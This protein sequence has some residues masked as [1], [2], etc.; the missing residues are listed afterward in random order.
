MNYFMET[1]VLSSL[2]VG[3][4]VIS[5]FKLYEPHSPGSFQILNPMTTQSSANSQLSS[6]FDC[7]Y[8]RRAPKGTPQAEFPLTCSH[9]H[10]TQKDQTENRSSIST[11]TPDESAHT[12]KQALR[13]DHL[14]Q[15]PLIVKLSNTKR[16]GRRKIEFAN[17]PILLLCRANKKLVICENIIKEAVGFRRERATR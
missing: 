17:P 15:Q 10:I 12:S 1:C 2:I 4:Y 8:R 11:D 14:R 3:S 13:R 5:I 7:H 6:M 16:E 9:S